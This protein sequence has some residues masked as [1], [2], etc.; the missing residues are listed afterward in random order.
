MGDKFIVIVYTLILIL[1][2]G[3]MFSFVGIE[4]SN[5]QVIEITIKDKYIKSG[6]KSGKYLVVDTNNN[7]YQITD[8]MFK[9]KFNSTDIYNSLEIGKTYKVETSGKRIHIFSWYQNINKI[10]EEEN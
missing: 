5:N 2:L 7:T 10:I 9:G 8:L 6:S 3:F 4:Y 1:G